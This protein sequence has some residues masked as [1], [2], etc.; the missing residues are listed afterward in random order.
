MF[1]RRRL[2][3]A[4]ALTAALA[5]CTSGGG[6]SEQQQPVS[7][8][9]DGAALLKESAEATRMIES[10]HF[11]LNV[12]GQVDAIP[13]QNAEGDITRKNGGGA[14][15]T[16]KL[17]FMGSVIEGKFVLTP[18]DLFIQGP[19]GGYQKLS[20]G[21]VTSIYD[22]SAI[23]DP[24][25]GVANVVAKVRQPRTEGEEEVDGVETYKVSGTVA[26]D[27]VLEI[28]PGVTQDVPVSVWIRT[29]NK[30]PAQAQVTVPQGDQEATVTLKLSEVGKDVTITPPN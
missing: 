15:G 19:T 20:A 29:D 16:V 13:V 17:T 18:D 10:G 4:L 12:D 25:R 23:L 22:P 6:G 9:P 7:D 21:L 24:D 8:L 26:K 14:Q 28:V 1:T 3:A 2:F 5:G 11:S 27:V 30:Q